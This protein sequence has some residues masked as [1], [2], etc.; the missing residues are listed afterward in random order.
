MRRILL[1]LYRVL[2]RLF[3]P[4]DLRMEY[5]AEIEHVF[6]DLLEHA[7]EKGGRAMLRV[8]LLEIRQLVSVVGPLS[9]LGPGPADRFRLIVGRFIDNLRSDL[10]NATTSLVRRPVFTVS[11]LTTLAIGIGLTAAVYSTAPM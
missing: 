6:T 3:A 5:G 1:L 10:I 2:L 4:R 9:R 8:W 7:R 11:V